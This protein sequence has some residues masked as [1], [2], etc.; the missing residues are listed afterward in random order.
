MKLKAMFA[1]RIFWAAAVGLLMV[2]A[3]VAI[4]LFPSRKRSSD[5][6]A[7]CDRGIYFW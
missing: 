1:S 3:R 7:V 6:G 2:V 4:A 5:T